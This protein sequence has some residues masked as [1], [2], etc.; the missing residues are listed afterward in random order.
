MC[1]RCVFMYEMVH[2][3]VC[4]RDSGTSADVLRAPLAHSG[5][6]RY[7]P[8]DPPCMCTPALSHRTRTSLLPGRRRPTKRPSILC[9]C[10]SSN[11]SSYISSDAEPNVRMFNHTHTSTHTCVCVRA[12]AHTQLPITLLECTLQGHSA[13]FVV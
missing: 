13:F 12:H 1:L 9:C 2:E 6:T 11:A 8:S 7:E 10:R 4:Q 5:R 3:I